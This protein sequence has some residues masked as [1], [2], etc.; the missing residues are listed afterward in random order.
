[1]RLFRYAVLAGVLAVPVLVITAPAVYA[2][3]EAGAGG[4]ST[5]FAMPSAVTP[6]ARATF[7]AHCSPAANAGGANAI[8]FGSSLGLP[9]R[10]PMQAE[11][12]GSFNFH[13][14]IGLPG[15]T[16]PG[17]YH[18]DIA[19][20]GGTSAMATLHVEALPSGGAA[21]GDGTT[22]TATSWN[23]LAVTGIALIGAGALVGGL[24]LRRNETNERS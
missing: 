15:S 13:L 10:I 18:L 12:P 5:A 4:G 11:A 22:S 3:A 8:L 1:M 7:V 17:T 19:C 6:G 14:T 2:A 21:T 16:V 20:P 24:A 9:A 23:A